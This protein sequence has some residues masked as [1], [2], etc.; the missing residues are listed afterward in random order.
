MANYLHRL[1]AIEAV[2]APSAPLPPLPVLVLGGDADRVVA[3]A[4]A[5]RMNNWP[6]DE[7]HPI[8]VMHI[9]F[10]ESGGG[11]G[12]QLQTCHRHHSLPTP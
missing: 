8:Q 3:I 6:D 4:E 10:V 1:A 9:H 7:M 2:L 12:Q 5:R 11:P